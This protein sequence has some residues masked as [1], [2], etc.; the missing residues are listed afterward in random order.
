MTIQNG[1]LADYE[2]LREMF[3]DGYFPN[4]LV[5]KG[6]VL[7][8]GLCEQI[9]AREPSDVAEVLALTHAVTEAFNALQEE[10]WDAGS[11]IETAAREAIA[12]D[13]AHILGVY[14]W[15][16]IDIEEAIAPRD[17]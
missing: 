13:I 10:F 12:G 3:A 2:F 7:L 8:V 17:W 14:G 1:E 6:K 16:E 4:A 11:E 5:E 15:A 9:E